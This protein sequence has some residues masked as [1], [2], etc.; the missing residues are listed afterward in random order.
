MTA[1][2][3]VIEDET[4]F[5]CLGHQPL[6]V[7]NERIEDGRSGL[8]IG[9]IQWQPVFMLDVAAPGGRSILVGAQLHVL[10][11][12]QDRPER[13]QLF[14]LAMIDVTLSRL[15]SFI[16]GLLIKDQAKR[17]HLSDK[18]SLVQVNGGIDGSV[19]IVT[20]GQSSAE[21][22]L[23]LALAI[24]L[25]RAHQRDPPGAV[26]RGAEPPHHV[27]ALDQIDDFFQIGLLHWFC[28]LMA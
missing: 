28:F 7:S 26:Q 20:H 15:I 13:I 24:L 16:S 22:V 8:A 2:L 11:L 19:N 25:D 27:D 9:F 14:Y 18:T 17:G 12:G 21:L 3:G 23:E 4:K 5:L 1:A 10:G 6:A